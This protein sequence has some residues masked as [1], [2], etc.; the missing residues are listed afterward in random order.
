MIM[1]L[2]QGAWILFKKKGGDMGKCL[3]GRDQTEVSF[4]RCLWQPYR[5][6]EE[7]DERNEG[8]EMQGRETANEQL[9]PATEQKSS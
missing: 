6:K 7:G 8:W 9:L 2:C 1:T 4:K 3:K 5:P